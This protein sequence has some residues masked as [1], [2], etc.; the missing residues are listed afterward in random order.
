MNQ[1]EDTLD[2]GEVY[3]RENKLIIQLRESLPYS[4]F[5][6]I[7]VNGGLL[8]NALSGGQVQEE[9]QQIADGG[10]TYKGKITSGYFNHTG[11]ISEDEAPEFIIQS[12]GY[13]V[14]EI[15]YRYHSSGED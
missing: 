11:P 5:V 8:K 1:S 3:I 6:Q 10:F 9:D 2:L 12:L 4:S 14:G 15:R 13:D 7:K